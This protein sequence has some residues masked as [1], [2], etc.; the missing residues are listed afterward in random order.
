MFKNLIVKNFVATLAVGGL[1][2]LAQLAGPGL[3]TTSPSIEQTAYP[4]RA[5]T[6]TNLRLDRNTMREGQKNVAR[7][8]VRGD[9][10]VPQGTV[11]FR[12]AGHSRTM[13]LID[14]RANWQLPKLKGGHTYTVSARYNGTPKVW[15]PSRDA[16]KLTVFKKQGKKKNNDQVLGEE[17]ERDNDD[18]G[19]A[20]SGSGGDSGEVAGSQAERA[21]T[22]DL[23]DTG[24]DENTTLYALGGLAL[25]IAGAASLLLWRRR[26]H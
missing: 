19:S 15:K 11:T 26:L 17:A 10:G 18:N 6:S 5:E 25:V 16:E 7:V 22:G 13:R 24:S 23:P 8:R 21:A 1:L 20:G 2:A 9:K 3:V 4:P 12:V 14:G